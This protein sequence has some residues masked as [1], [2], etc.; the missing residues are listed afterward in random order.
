MH[1]RTF[2]PALRALAV[3][4]A[5]CAAP[6]AA[7]RK[8]AVPGVP[9]DPSRAQVEI[10]IDQRLGER[11]PLDARFRDE[12]GREVRLGD[13]CSWRWSTTSAARCARRC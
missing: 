3:V 1:V 7:Q 8:L 12:A 9:F 5:A 2:V 10:G 11:L 4:L 13:Y 6:A